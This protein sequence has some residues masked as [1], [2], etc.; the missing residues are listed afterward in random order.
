MR[1]PRNAHDPLPVHL[2]RDEIFAIA[3]DFA[4][5]RNF[6]VGEPCARVWEQLGGKIGLMNGMTDVIIGSLPSDCSDCVVA[7]GPDDLLALLPSAD[8]VDHPR[9]N[10]EIA[11]AIGHVVLHF[12][13]VREVYG[14]TAA[15]VAR[16][17]PT[18]P[19][20]HRCKREV[21]QFAFGLLVPRDRLLQEWDRTDGDLSQLREIFRIPGAII[22]GIRDAFA[23]EARKAA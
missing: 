18:G 1:L 4:T 21:I 19:E 22:K 7:Y 11:K 6:S 15:M 12:P 14:Q 17:Y 20:D 2:S 10:L 5:R 8:P 3:T 23:S 16:Y 13:K 9:T